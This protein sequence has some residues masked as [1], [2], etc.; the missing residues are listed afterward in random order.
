MV[1]WKSDDAP[2]D[3]AGRIAITA[4][5]RG[6]PQSGLVVIEV[7]GGAPYAIRHGVLSRDTLPAPK[8]VHGRLDI[9]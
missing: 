9:S 3:G 6:R 1:S 2:D 8:I 7:V 4:A 5:G